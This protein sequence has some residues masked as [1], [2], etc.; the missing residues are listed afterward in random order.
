MSLQLI[1]AQVEYILQNSEKARN[2]DTYGIAQ[3][4]L[5][6][7]PKSIIETPRGKAVLLSEMQELPREDAFKRYRAW[8]NSKGKYLPS[9]PEVTKARRQ[10]VKDWKNSL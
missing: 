5:H 3:L 1:K 4:W 8:F 7:Y 10:R 9:D 6:F 2:S